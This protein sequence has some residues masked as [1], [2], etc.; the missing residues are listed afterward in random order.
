MYFKSANL[1]QKMYLI[2]ESAAKYVFQICESAAKIVF[3]LR[4]CGLHVLVNGHRENPSAVQNFIVLR[5]EKD[6]RS[7]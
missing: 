4:I 7:A 1:R 3:N 2:S 6:K 5:P